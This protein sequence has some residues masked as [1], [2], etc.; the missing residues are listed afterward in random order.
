MKTIIAIGGGEIGRPGYPIETTQIDKEIIRLTGKKSP[1][2]LFVPTASSDSESYYEV[3]KKYFGKKLGCK[4]DVLYLI[5]EKLSNKEI[6]EKILNSDILYVGGGDTLKMMKIWKKNGVDKILK[7][8]YEKG[9]VLS[10]LSAGS[11][12]WFKFGNSDS[13]KFTDP[14]AD[15]IKVSGLGLINALHCPHYDF[16]KNRKPDLKKM[17]KKTSGVAMAIDNCCAIE[18]IDD[19]YRIISSKSSANAYKVFWKGNNYHEE[20]IKKEREFKPLK[21]LLKK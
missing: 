13:R 14:N 1:K 4:T 7:Q 2:L 5:K 15:L 11:I 19:K 12:C 8:A 3:V 20:V 9:I 17:M 18:V 16:D 6:K 10:G 21:D